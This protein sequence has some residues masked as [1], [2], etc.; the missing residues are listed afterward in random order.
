MKNRYMKVNGDVAT[1]LPERQSK[2]STHI[3]NLSDANYKKAT[4]SKWFKVVD[5]KPA[6][7]SS[8]EMAK[9]DISNKKENARKVLKDQ[10]ELDMSQTT[11]ELNSKVFWA[12]PA[13]EQ[14]FSGR[15]RQM[16]IEGL[17]VTKWAQGDNV[18]EVTLDELKTVVIEGTKKNAALWDK[19]IKDIEA[20]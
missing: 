17:S 11:V 15:I 18:F 9:Q 16:E 5:G 20:L 19:Y 13:S 12:D 8:D 2:I 7:K 3:L 14:N 1:P 4:S 6:I 10:L